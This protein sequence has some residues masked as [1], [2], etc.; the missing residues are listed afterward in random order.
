MTGRFRSPKG[1]GQGA[2]KAFYPDDPSNVYHSYLRDHTK[3]R[4]L[5]AAKIAH[6][7]HLHAH[8]WLHSPDS[9]EGHY[10]DS[11]LING[12]ISYTQEIAYGGSGNRNLTP[13]DSIFHCHFYPHFAQGMWSL[14]RVH[15][16]LEEGT[17]IDP[18]TGRPVTGQ[19][20]RALPDGEIEAGT[21][22]PA[23]VP[24]PSLALAPPPSDVQ[25]IAQGRQAKVLPEKDGSY[26]NPGYPFFVPGLGG[27]RPPQPPKDF[28]PMTDAE[29]QP[30]KDGNG[31]PRYLDGGL[32]RHLII[33]GE[34]VRE[35]H[36]PWDFSKDFVLMDEAQEAQRN[37][38]AKAGWAAAVNLPEEGTVVEQAAMKFHA[39]NP[40][41]SYTPE[42]KKA[43]FEVNGLPAQPGA[44][45]ADPG[46]TDDGKPVGR[47]IVYKGADI[48][49]DVAFNK[50]GWHYPQ[51]RF[52][53]LWGDV[54]D[55]VSGARPPEP[56]FFRADSKTVVE[57]WQTNLVP[58]YYQMD[59]FQVR[60]P[61]D[62]IGQH[63]H[64]VK[65]DVTASDGAANGFNYEDSTFSPDEVRERIAAIN[66][67]QEW[68]TFDIAS[69]QYKG[70][71]MPDQ[72]RV[73]P[74]TTSYAFFGPEPAGQNWDGAQTT[75]QRWYADPLLDNKGRD[76]TLRTVF[77]HDH[78]SPSTHQQTGLYAGLLVEPEDSE[79]Y[80][81]DRPDK[82]NKYG[83]AQMNTRT[84][85]VRD[86]GPTSWNA[87]VV[88]GTKG[89]D[90][91][92]EFA[93]EFQ[94]MALA[95]T[96]PS[97]STYG[98]AFIG[99]SNLTNVYDFK[100]SGTLAAEL[101]A[102]DGKTV[103]TS[104]IKAFA[105]A[106]KGSTAGQI[107]LNPAARV[108]V[109]RQV[110]QGVKT[111]AGITPV[112]YGQWLIT[113]PSGVYTIYAAIP[114]PFPKNAKPPAELYVN[115]LLESA[116]TTASVSPAV[117]P[118]PVP[119]ALAAQ[120]SLN[121]ITLSAS[122]TVEQVAGGAVWIVLDKG[123][124]SGLDRGEFYP[125]KDTSSGSA[126]RFQVFLPMTGAWCDS[127]YAVYPANNFGQPQL[128]SSGFQGTYSVNYRNEPL[129]IRVNP[130]KSVEPGLLEPLGAPEEATAT[131]LAHVLRSIKRTDK[132]LNVQPAPDQLVNPGDPLGFRFPG[133]PL[134][135]GVLDYDP[136]TPLLRAYENDKVQIRTLVGAHQL[137]HSFNVHG[138][139]WYFEPG[140]DNFDLDPTFDNNSG[141]RNA[142]AMG[143]SE[144][145]E[146]NFVV[147]PSSNT[148]H[149]IG[150][151]AQYFA[152]YPYMTDSGVQSLTNGNWGLIRAYGPGGENGPLPDL[153]TVPS[154]PD[155]KSPGRF[156]R[157][158]NVTTNQPAP[159]RSFDVV[160]ISAK[161]ALPAQGSLVYNSRTPAPGIA[162]P[163][164]V[165]YVAASDL[166]WAKVGVAVTAGG[167]PEWT[168]VTPDSLGKVALKSTVPVE[169]L[170]LRVSAGDFITVNLF[171]AFDPGAPV[172][173]TGVSPQAPFGA[174]GSPAAGTLPNLQIFMSADVGLHPQVLSFDV[175]ASNGINAGW[176]PITT[177]AP[178]DPKAAKVTGVSYQW[179]AGNI[180]WDQATGDPI[181]QPVEFGALNLV[182]ADPLLQHTH[183]LIAALVVEPEGA[184]WSFDEDAAGNV[185]TRTSA[186]VT[187]GS[188]AL[189]FREFVLLTQDDLALPRY[190]PPPQ[191]PT[192]NG[193]NYG[194]EPFNFRN[195]P[196][197]PPMDISRAVSDEQVNADPQTPVFA[198][199][200]GTPVRWRLLHPGGR[201]NA[202]VFTID[203]HVWQEEPYRRGS[204]VI[205]T[206]PHSQW[207]GSR[208][209]LM[210]NQP[211][212]IVLDRA[213][214]TSA[215]TG[216]FLYRSCDNVSYTGGWWGIMRVTEPQK[217]G[218]VITNAT[219]NTTGQLVVTGWTVVDAGKGKL[220]DGVKISLVDAMGATDVP[221]M[222]TANVTRGEWNW[223]FTSTGTFTPA[224]LTGKQI[225]A[226]SAG[227]GVFT[228]PVSPTVTLFPTPY[229]PPSAVAVPLTRPSFRLFHEMTPA[230]I[231][232]DPDFKFRK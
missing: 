85:P 75:V 68:Y 191:Q 111:A 116:F 21:P 180:R 104:V 128:V 226:T 67:K 94:D 177:A 146:M 90:S 43:E 126:T 170:V 184:A 192:K 84:S 28:A 118:G 6:V 197:G 152:D 232:Q 15:D 42:G 190:V 161:Q 88:A 22:I 72:L 139:K 102:N 154:N 133:K 64:L 160:A 53:T 46:R 100:I 200:A 18:K 213:G 142:Q 223:T 96:A 61:T 183:S 144:H 24:M 115:N 34:V 112:P 12:G 134:T 103:P 214:G 168:Q 36:S 41:A 216:D 211:Y 49:L 171:N 97:R 151:K 38:V 66:V 182:A 201:G 172:F 136:Y 181:G 120:L 27:H 33:G 121:G 3:F 222:V 203:G 178:L 140:L 91:Y 29:G 87:V 37:Y 176:N 114:Q 25:L 73:E 131:D 74:Y 194:T 156:G 135:P 105:T 77:T 165:L 83:F 148:K 150:G 159:E 163:N 76:R 123:T 8:Q 217:D 108:D 80:I 169:P 229:P 195:W 188:K 167:N 14:W 189:L 145:F 39:S 32:P 175:S 9:D 205:G 50:K 199:N 138:V 101:N 162:D 99:D 225:R 166:D 113:D 98:P 5:H 224:A 65:F 92:R 31:N 157:P 124:A 220:A 196:A 19:P 149:D 2:T 44:P 208:A 78:F 207:M 173:T 129:A 210:P 212:E 202:E 198:V 219:I 141:F 4:I 45:Y 17:K 69:D 55:T 155:R 221:G 59:D 227:G 125:L 218:I 81:A 16:V 30:V 228:V 122:A 40:I 204:T 35:F 13:G 179:Y 93:L 206:N 86:G 215:A 60:T 110:I 107:N 57:Y 56:L 7:H 20:N 23:V 71:K 47:K 106:T 174:N 63:I 1:P 130:S 137:S 127:R 89:A 26:R 143:I 119:Q 95:Y 153:M 48:Q 186:N 79:W 117:T 209:S 193:F 158:R 187:D 147:P 58:N 11:Q 52:I 230:E 164:A 82:S 10:L 185:V 51:Q 109:V 70:S 231:K 54:A 132:Q 62:V